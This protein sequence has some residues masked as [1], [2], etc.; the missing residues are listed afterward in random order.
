MQVTGLKYNREMC[1]SNYPLLWKLV[2]IPR[3]VNNLL[4]ITTIRFRKYISLTLLLIIM[5]SSIPLLGNQLLIIL[6]HYYK[7]ITINSICLLN[8]FR[9]IKRLVQ[10][11]N[12]QVGT[13]R[14]PQVPNQWEW[15]LSQLLLVLLKLL[16]FQAHK[17]KTTNHAIWLVESFS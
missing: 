2:T 9:L 11:K 16:A 8:K 12:V 14:S 1:C 15:V 13:S 3:Q 6:N 4:I 5:R 7:K 10:L 17:F